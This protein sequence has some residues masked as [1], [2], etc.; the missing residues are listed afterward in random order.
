MVGVFFYGAVIMHKI[1]LN[2]RELM[3]L[4]QTVEHRRLQTE[5]PTLKARLVEL[6]AKIVEQVMT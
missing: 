1:E 5:N 4:L 6:N 2:F 3:L